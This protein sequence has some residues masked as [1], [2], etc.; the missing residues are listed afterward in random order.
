MSLEKKMTKTWKPGDSVALRGIYND[1]VW[2]IRSAVVVHDHHEEVA[3]AVLPGAE[4]Y[5]P[6]S[7]INGKHG[8]AGR[9]DRWGE[10]RSDNWKMQRYTWHTNRLLILLQ[11]G[12][13]YSVIYFWRADTNQFLCYYVNFELPFRRS[14]L[15]FDTL[16]LELDII[17]EPT[18]E[19]SWKDTEEYSQGINDGILLKEWVD[20]IECAKP[21]V[22]EKIEKREYPLDGK[23][24]DWLP[25]P[26]WTVPPLPENWDKI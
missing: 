26:N 19:W 25:D 5:A 18:Y 14:R 20:Q 9:W 24:L 13:P 1:R 10:Y 21:E 6:E 16:D 22:F 2:S 4:C 15:G 3:L 11:S 12:K 23:W 7:Y 17:V 8:P